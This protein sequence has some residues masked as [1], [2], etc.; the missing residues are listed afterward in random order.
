MA[1]DPIRRLLVAAKL[2]Y[3]NSEGC[4]VNH[5]SDDFAIHG[6]PGWLTDCAADI[7]AAEAALAKPASSPAPVRPIGNQGISDYQREIA[8]NMAEG[9]AAWNAAR[10]EA[11]PSDEPVSSPAVCERCEGTGFAYNQMDERTE[12]CPDCE[13]RITA[14]SSPAGGDV[15]EALKAIAEGYAVSVFDDRYI[16]VDNPAYRPDDGSS[17]KLV[18]DAALSQSTSAGRVGE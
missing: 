16:I 3:A 10:Q 14:A 4:A 12:E 13:A 1:D 15:R 2:L 8:R 11:L 18:I 6:L 17:P 9:F 5:Y 7:Q